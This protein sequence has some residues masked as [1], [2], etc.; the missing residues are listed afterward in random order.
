MRLQVQPLEAA[1]YVAEGMCERLG[2]KHLLVGVVSLAHRHQLAMRAV[3]CM[4]R[5]AG[6]DID[7]VCAKM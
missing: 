1:V 6:I 7:F 4:H 5:L 3:C 2:V